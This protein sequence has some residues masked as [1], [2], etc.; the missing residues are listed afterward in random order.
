MRSRYSVNMKF[1]H[2]KFINANLEIGTL[3]NDKFESLE[4]EIVEHR[5]LCINLCEGGHWEIMQIS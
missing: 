1:R 4:F 2:G 3:T 5:T